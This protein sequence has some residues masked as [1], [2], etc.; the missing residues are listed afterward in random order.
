[1]NRVFLWATYPCTGI[2]RSYDRGN[3]NTPRHFPK[4]GAFGKMHKCSGAV[5]I[6]TPELVNKLVEK[7]VGESPATVV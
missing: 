6:R 2:P 7:V 3:A 5:Q 1:V 4:R